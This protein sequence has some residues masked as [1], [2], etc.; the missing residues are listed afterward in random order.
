[1]LIS[2]TGVLDDGTPYVAG[3]PTNPRRA[4]TVV[5]GEDTTLQVRVVTP[6]GAAVDTSSPA[7]LVLTVKKRPQ[8]YVAVATV[9]GTVAAGVASFALTPAA[10]KN[11][12]PGLF[13]YD[14]WLTKA[15]ARSAVVPLSPLHLEASATAIP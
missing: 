9:T 4:V 5:R 10:F 6:Q 13:C 11:E 14:V 8:D 15:G 7:V 12:L 2:L 3:V 1:M